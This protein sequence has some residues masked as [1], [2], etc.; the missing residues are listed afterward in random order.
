M[1]IGN[2]SGSGKLNVAINVT[3]LIDVLL[4]LLIIF[5][6]IAPVPTQGL[7]ARVPQP[8]SDPNHHLDAAVV[9]QVLKTSGGQVN[10]KLDQ[11]D[12][13]L[14]DLANRLKVVF[15]IRANKIV[16][17]KGDAGLDFSAIAQVL[18]IAKGA[19]ADNIGLITR[20][21]AM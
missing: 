7:D 10:Y 4:V 11:E 9:V 2:G 17:I 13:A 5:M 1:A 19:G 8:S 15:S 21:D 20:K 16:F 14:D 12:I 6:V 3:P 18:D